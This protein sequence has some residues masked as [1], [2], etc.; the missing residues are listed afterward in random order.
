MEPAGILDEKPEECENMLELLKKRSQIN[1][2]DEKKWSNYHAMLHESTNQYGNALSLDNEGSLSIQSSMEHG[3][4]RQAGQAN[5]ALSIQVITDM[6]PNSDSEQSVCT[7]RDKLKNVRDWRTSHINDILVQGNLSYNSYHGSKDFLL[8][9]E[10]PTSI[11]LFNSSFFVSF[12]DSINAIDSEIDAGFPF[13]LPLNIGIENALIDADGCFVSVNGYTSLVIKQGFR[14]FYFDSHSRD[15]QG[16]LCEN[17]SSIVIELTDICH[18]YH[19]L[20]EFVKDDPQ[21]LFEITSVNVT[22]SA[23][24]KDKVIQRRHTMMTKQTWLK[25][26]I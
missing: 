22:I 23:K 3:N 14:L 15:L 20:K 11:E 16:K 12:G 7:H 25:T 18:L 5:G 8:V 10:M 4:I 24:D 1:E 19:I 13:A 21:S 6:S 9:S 2:A 26:R 17:G